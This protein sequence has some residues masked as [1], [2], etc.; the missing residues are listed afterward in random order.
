[1]RRALI[2]DRHIVAA[3]P[4]QVGIKI[5]GYDCFGKAFDGGGLCSYTQQWL[6]K[7]GAGGRE[8]DAVA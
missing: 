5:A 8:W 4:E 3:T 1:M 6:E 7:A 2:A